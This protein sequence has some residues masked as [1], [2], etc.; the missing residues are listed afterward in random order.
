[1]SKSVKS[2]LI[3]G[4]V[5][6]ESRSSAAGSR[7]LQL[8]ELFTENGFDTHFAS[9]ASRSE[10]SDMLSNRVV[11]H[12]IKLNDA[13]FDHFVTGLNPTVVMFDRFM[14]E[15]QY[16]WRVAKQC[17]DAIRILDTEDLHS[18]RQTRQKCV[19]E[20]IL[21]QPES[22][23]QEDITKREIAAIYR[24]DLTLMISS[25]EMDLLRNLFNLAENYLFYL[26]FLLDPITDDERSE[27]LTYE[28]RDGFIMIGNFLHEPN[29]DAVKWLKKEIWPLIRAQLPDVNLNIYGSYASNSELQMDSRKDG[30]YVH[31][32]TDTLNQ[33]IMKSKVMLAPLRFGAGLKGKLF[34]AMQSGTP[35]VTTTIGSEG[36]SD[37]KKWC[38]SV[39]DEAKLFAEA[40]VKLYTNRVFWQDAQMRGVTILNNDFAKKEYNPSFIEKINELTENRDINRKNNFIG[41]MLMHHT[42]AGSRYMSK[43][44][45][46]KEKRLGR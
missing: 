6:P 37:A 13:S 39:N 25:Y 44:I 29:R 28:Q 2:V 18:L 24:S 42:M 36:I 35:S 26:P 12:D 1:M 7:M 3:I 22:M 20:G 9:A 16:G 23:L 41:S 19:N 43:W 14:T 31:G 32:R 8:I 4:K 34:D 40:A 46:E 17:P 11:C 10:Y 30:F 5:W 27:W 33:V 38:G 45:E 21:F 15:E